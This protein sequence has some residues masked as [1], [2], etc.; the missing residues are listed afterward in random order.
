MKK[1]I[2][3]KDNKEKE[4]FKTELFNELLEYHFEKSLGKDNHNNLPWRV[5]L[6]DNIQPHI[7]ILCDLSKWLVKRGWNKTVVEEL[8]FVVA[9]DK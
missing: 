1:I 9:D 5:L 6:E 2:I 3:E 7:D 8:F 4:K